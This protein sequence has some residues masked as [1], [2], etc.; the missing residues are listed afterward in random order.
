MNTLEE[1]YLT[2][3][4]DRLALLRSLWEFAKTV[5][6]RATEGYSYGYP[7]LLLNERPLI[8]FSNAKNHMSVYPFSP[9][10]IDAIKGELAD[11]EYSK[12]LVRFATTNPLP[13]EIIEAMIELR[14]N[15]LEN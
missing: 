4:P 6:P 8:G 3:D 5:E 13:H 11:F 7:A 10:V 14:R 15:Q 2:I 9:K 12:G 1:T